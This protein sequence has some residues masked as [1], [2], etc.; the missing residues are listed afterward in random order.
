[1]TVL[2]NHSRKTF[3]RKLVKQ[4]KMSGFA[5]NTSIHDYADYFGFC[6]TETTT[7]SIEKYWMQRDSYSYVVPVT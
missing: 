3:I 5:L 1:M 2:K 7:S 4:G 6:S